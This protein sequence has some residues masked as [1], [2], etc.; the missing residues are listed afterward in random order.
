MMRPLLST[1]TCLMLGIYAQSAFALDGELGLDFGTAGNSRAHADSLASIRTMSAV[2]SLLPRYQ[3]AGSAYVYPNLDYGL[4]AAALDSANG[5]ISLG[6]LY[7]RES[8][9]GFETD[10]LPGWKLPD[11]EIE[12]LSLHSLTGASLAVSFLNRSLSLGASGFYVGTSNDLDIL[13]HAFELNLSMGAKFSDQVIV[14][15][16]AND[17]LGQSNGSTL[18][19]AIRWGVLD[20]SGPL[21]K[22]CMTPTDIY[23][24]SGGIEV[25]AGYSLRHESMD[26]VGVG[27]DIPLACSF[28]LHGGVQKRFVDD[29]M[30][31][32]TGFLIENVSNAVGYD[33]Q[34]RDQGG[35]WEHVHLITIQFRLSNAPFA[36]RA[37]L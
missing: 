4:T 25:D 9:Q 37:H 11:E 3:L 8:I 13:T 28:S 16:A 5:A 23:Y 24:S 2:T 32:G 7:H 6:I 20:V 33:V 14:G 1:I 12:Q 18:E 31:Y 36:P 10:L 30:R 29:E 22:R 35:I 27:F 17:I 19:S 34:L 15:L 26:F 21:W